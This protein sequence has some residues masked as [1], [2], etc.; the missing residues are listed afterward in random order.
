MAVDDVTTVEGGVD[1][2]WPRLPGDV[3]ARRATETV[4]CADE[5]SGVVRSPAGASCG[6]PAAEVDPARDNPRSQ[7]RNASVSLTSDEAS[8][9]TKRASSARPKIVKRLSGTRSTGDTT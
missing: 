9:V 7:V 8:Q 2:R 6:P 1:N 3:S 4:Q 5:S